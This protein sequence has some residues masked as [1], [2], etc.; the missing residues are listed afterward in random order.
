M[1][2]TARSAHH[3][4][5]RTQAIGGE[6]MDRALNDFALDLH[7]AEPPVPVFEAAVAEPPPRDRSFLGRLSIAEWL[8]KHREYL[9]K[10][11]EQ[12]REVPLIVAD[13]LLITLLPTLFYGLVTGIATGS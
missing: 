6:T 2:P 7:P 4:T 10:Q 8:L 11:I 13:L 9:L 5:R 1:N 12:G 3:A